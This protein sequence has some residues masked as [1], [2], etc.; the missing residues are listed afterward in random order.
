MK[1]YVFASLGAVVLLG[2]GCMDAESL[3]NIDKTNGVDR[4]IT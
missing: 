1:A 2:A 3:S 4:V